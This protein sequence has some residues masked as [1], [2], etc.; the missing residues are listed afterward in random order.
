MLIQILPIQIPKVWEVIK[1]AAVKSDNVKD[2]QVEV[3]ANNLLHDL[4][5]GK[6]HCYVVKKE[7]QI[8]FVALLE[9]RVDS[10]MDKKF[11]YFSNLYSFSPNNFLFWQSIIE[12]L[13]IIAKNNDC[14]FLTGD[15]GNPQM[16]EIL[17]KINVPCVS[18]KY[19]YSLKE[20]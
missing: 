9:F 8:T 11:I 10:T 3:Y 13:E 12:S 14:S 16:W 20:I 15:V 19:T 5:A 17:N 2:K 6:K 1:F 4:L 18:R 7:N